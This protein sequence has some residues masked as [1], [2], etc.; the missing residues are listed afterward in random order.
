MWP[1]GPTTWIE[2]RVLKVSIPFTWNLPP[3]RRKLAGAIDYG[4]EVQV[5]GPA[6]ELMPN[7][8]DGLS[9]TIGTSEPGVL[10]RVNPLATKTT[11]GCTNTCGFCAVPQIEGCFQELREWP[12]GTVYCDNN[13]LAAS[14]SHV[15]RVL[16]QAIDAGEADFNQGLDCRLLTKD[17]AEMIAKI[18]KPVVRLALDSMALADTW[19]AAFETLRQEGLAKHKIRSYAIVAHTTDPSECWGRCEYIE[20]HKIKAYPMWFHPLDS[21]VYNGVTP[22]QRRLGWS[23]AEQRRIMNYYYQHRGTNP[24]KEAS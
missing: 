18:K 15:E 11:T 1:K 14:D 2:G 7:F 19:T 3:M 6:V 12:K 16:A 24:L 8:F 13:L 17:H 10:Q 21:L 5:G 23:R 4:Y 20:S 9:V 22:Q